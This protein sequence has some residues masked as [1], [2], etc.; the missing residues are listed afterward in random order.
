[1]P[2]NKTLSLTVT[3][4]YP[5]IFLKPGREASLLRG[6]PWIFSGALASVEGKPNPGDIAVAVTHEGVPL[7]LG[8]YNPV[9]DISFRLLTTDTTTSINTLFWHTRIRASLA[10]REKIVP[11]GTTAYRLINAEGDWMPGL[12]V[13]RYGDYLVLSIATAGME[14]H[15]HG[16][17]NVFSEEL[18]PLGVYER[19]EGRARQLE[20]LEDRTCSVY[21]EQPPEAIEITENRLH[22]KVDIIKGQKT[23][24]FLDQRPNREIVEQF[25]SQAEVLN[26][27]S[28]TGA[29][30]VYAAR[31][32][33]TR[34]VSVDSS[35]T[36][37]EIARYNLQRNSFSTERHPVFR[38]DVFSYLRKTDELFDVIIL[39]P[40]AFAGSKKDIVKA[41]RG[42]K[43]INLYAARHL[44]EGALLVTFSCSNYIDETLFQ[45]IVLG[46]IRDA[47]K[48]AQLLHIMG[49]GQDHP[50]NLA[51]PE[52]RY[53]K[54]LLLSLSG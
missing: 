41:A 30:S 39:D 42:Y 37:S 23:G 3:Q 7:A 33:A 8:F 1:M 10:L 6:H 14:Q 12:I 2:E 47:G 19:S 29:F 45:K 26:C 17:L 11:E 36:A 40:P 18:K 31:G 24:F 27:F 48:T 16:I 46:A 25:S 38:D 53:L 34:V 28:Y 52:G 15:R 21:S 13:D 5:K 54:G 9:S 32:G 43:D 49:P 51:H 4:K 35:E 22:F 20:G 44:R 50:T